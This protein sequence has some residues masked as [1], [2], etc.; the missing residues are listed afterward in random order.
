M[1]GACGWGV[2]PL[3]NPHMGKRT[4][5]LLREQLNRELFS[6]YLYLSMAAY[7]HHRRRGI[8]HVGI[9]ELVLQRTVGGGRHG[10]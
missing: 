5:A 2:E 4:D 6:A 3:Y 1:L 9:P 7:F 10:G 8:R